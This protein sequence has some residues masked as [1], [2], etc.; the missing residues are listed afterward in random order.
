MKK[1][2]SFLGYSI[3]ALVIYAVVQV[4]FHSGM[5]E[6]ILSKYVNYNVY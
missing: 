3:L 5:I 1:S 4:L 2:K 6:Y